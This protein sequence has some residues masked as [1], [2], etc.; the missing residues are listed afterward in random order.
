MKIVAFTCAA[1]LALPLNA[2]A[3]TTR[4]RFTPPIRAEHSAARKAEQQDPLALMQQ[5]ADEGWPGW[6][7]AGMVIAA[8]GASFAGW[9][10]SKLD[11]DTPPD[12][13]SEY[14]RDEKI[15]FG[16]AVVGVSIIIGGLVWKGL[17]ER[18]WI[19]RPRHG[20]VAAGGKIRWGGKK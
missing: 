16:M 4:I 14:E 9:A 1:L 13:R 6:F 17:P 15:G 2:P 12:V 8:G 18:A 7:V 3:Q 20:G 19:T 10:M 11:Y 5:G